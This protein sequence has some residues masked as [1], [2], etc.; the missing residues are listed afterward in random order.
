MPP[1]ISRPTKSSSTNVTYTGSSMH[2]Y[3][4]FGCESFVTKHAYMR[5][6]VCADYL[7]SSQHISSLAIIHTKSTLKRP[8]IMC[9]NK[10]NMKQQFSPDGESGATSA[11]MIMI[12]TNMSSSTYI[13]PFRLNDFERKS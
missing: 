10:S 8:C 1:H 7:M 13:H 11:T 5:S 12:F 4:I 3:S 2:K 9:V 6:G